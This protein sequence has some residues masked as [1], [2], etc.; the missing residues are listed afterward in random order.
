MLLGDPVEGSLSP[1]IHNAAFR[2]L[3]MPAIYV[4]VRTL[5]DY[6]GDMV[7]GIRALGIKG[8]NVTIPHKVTVMDL[9]DELDNS[10]SSVE[11]VNTVKNKRGKLV[12]FNTD[13][14]GALQALTD[15][16]G[17]VKGKRVLLLGAGGAARAIAYALAG[18]G[19]EV[20]VANRTPSRAEALASIVRKNLGHEIQVLSL[21]KRELAK[22]IKDVEILINATS[23]GMRPHDDSAL[24]TSDILH[25]E[26]TVMD[27]VYK[28]LETKLLREAKKAGCRTINGLN[29]LVNQAA[30]SFKIWTGRKP[31]VKVMKEAAQRVLEG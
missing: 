22:T 26:V 25:R 5:S 29:M 24:V 28:P 12:G 27:I 23:V 10:A 31:P 13:G 2:S 15:E 1:I 4:A 8:F 18:E 30:M 16:L 9:L 19:C 21:E 3:K 7:N 11:A 20:K 17:S 14:L 6:L